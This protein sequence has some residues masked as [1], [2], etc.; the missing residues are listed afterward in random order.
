MNMILPNGA[1]QQRQQ[2]T[3]LQMMRMDLA[4]S[5]LPQLAQID[6][7]QA[8]VDYDSA[9]EDY[10]TDCQ[11][12]AKPLGL[13]FYQGQYYSLSVNENTVDGP[14]MSVETG[15]TVDGDDDDSFDP[16]DPATHRE[17]PPRPTIPVFHLREGYI[18]RLI[19]EGSLPSPPGLR[20]NS[21]IACAV[22]IQY[23]NNLMIR[24]G[25]LVQ[26]TD[27]KDGSVLDGP[28]MSDAVKLP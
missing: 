19:E 25:F 26:K 27:S 7:Q 2:A 1:A 20:I 24:L 12:A 16:F 11:I 22:A 5:I 8:L 9:V 23:A 10:H 28:N 18:E 14:L 17:T 13:I 3:M 4:K 6:Y 21:D 15:P